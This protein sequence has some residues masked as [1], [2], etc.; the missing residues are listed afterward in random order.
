MTTLSTGSGSATL[1]SYEALRSAPADLECWTFLPADSPLAFWARRQA[2]ETTI[3]RVD[4]ESISASLT[5]LDAQLSADGI[6]ELLF[7][8][9]SR[10]RKLRAGP[11][12]QR[13]S[14]RRQ[15][16]TTGGCV[17][18]GTEQVSCEAVGRQPLSGPSDCV[19][20]GSAQI[21]TWR[22]GTGSRSVPYTTKG[23]RACSHV[24]ASRYVSGGLEPPTLRQ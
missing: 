21:C 18:L 7:G 9:A 19:V 1:H 5:P 3:H 17:I 12:A 2:H 6:D 20:R 22:F 13:W 10:G 8:F 23:T 16:R 24:S 11:R 15:T 4:V 14:W